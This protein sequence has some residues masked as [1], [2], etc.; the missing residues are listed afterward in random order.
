[1]GAGGLEHS[2]ENKGKTGSDGLSGA[3]SGASGSSEGDSDP[4]LRELAQRWPSL[5]P[6]IRAAILRLARGTTEGGAA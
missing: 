5:M 2:H 3:E 4:D 6:Q 1:M